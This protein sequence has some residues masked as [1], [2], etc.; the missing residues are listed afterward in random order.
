MLSKETGL[1]QTL[2]RL[3]MFFSY[4]LPL[5]RAGI[6]GYILEAIIRKLPEKKL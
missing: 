6:V 5:E 4:L 3:I 2:S 1:R